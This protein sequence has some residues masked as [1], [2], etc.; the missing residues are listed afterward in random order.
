MFIDIYK[1][2]ILTVINDS[3]STSF[4]SSIGVLK[5]NNNIY[6]LLG[7]IHKKGDKFNIPKK[8]YNNIKAFI[9]GKNK[10]FLSFPNIKALIF[11]KYFFDR[12]NLSPFL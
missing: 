10:N 9:F 3:K 11:L 6:W 4:S 5:S 1:N 7:G 12:S 2:K 8:Y